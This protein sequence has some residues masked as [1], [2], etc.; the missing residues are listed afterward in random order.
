VTSVI[1]FVEFYND[2]WS[3]DPSWEDTVILSWTIV[4]PAMYHLTACLITLR[5]L[6]HW[7][8]IE[9]PLSSYLSKVSPRAKNFRSILLV[10]AKPSNNSQDS[11]DDSSGFGNLVF[12]GKNVHNTCSIVDTGPYDMQSLPDTKKIRLEQSYEIISSRA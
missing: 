7:I 1:R 3:Y 4:E 2:D 12:H 9:T 8:V 10:K 5:P 6:I 11:A